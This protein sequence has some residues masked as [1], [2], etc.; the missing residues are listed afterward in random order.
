MKNIICLSGKQYSGK[1]TLAK[2]IMQ[3]IPS[4]KRVAIGDAIK[5]E[6]GRLNNLTYETIDKNKGKYRTGLIE[7]GNKGRNIHPDYWLNKIIEL[8]YDV[9]VPDVRLIHEAEVFKNAGAYLIRVE[10]SEETRS[11]RGIITNSNDATECELD[12][13]NGFD[14][15][16][17]NEKDEEA[18]KTNAKPLIDKICLKF[19]CK[20]CL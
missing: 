17:S 18:L 12:L 14:Y 4:F 10:A 8:D 7:L 16:I 2:V 15:I 20:S 5:L 19:S 11:K 9:I 6:F 1:D 13:Y 3:A